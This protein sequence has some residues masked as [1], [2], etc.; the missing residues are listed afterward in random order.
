MI[1]PTTSKLLTTWTNPET[2]LDIYLL[3]EKVAP[4]QQS[5]YFVNDGM[6]A[7]GR[8]LWFYCSYPP[9]GSGSY[10]RTLGLVDFEQ[11]LV[12]HFPDTQFQH[13]SPYVDPANGDVYWT[14]GASIWRRS[15]DPST[16]AECV[17]SLP[18]EIVG[19][20]TV[21]RLATHLSKSVDGTEFFADVA[22]GTQYVFGTL[23]LDGS[24]FRF[25]H[26]F[27][28]NHNHAQFSPIDPDLVLFAEEFHIDPITGLRIPITNRMWSIRR[29][30]APR[31]LLPTPT[32]LSHEWWDEDGTHAWA[33][34]GKQTWRINVETAEVEV[35]EWP[36]NCWH[37]HGTRNG[38]GLICD[39]TQ[40]FYRGCP[41]SVHFLNRRSNT[42]L[43]VIDNPGIDGIAGSNYHIDPHPRFCG[44]DQFVI[45]TATVRGQMDLAIVKTADL[46]DRTA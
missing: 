23:P 12:R 14:T 20:R 5:F 19:H 37:A 46:I 45:F 27:D 6:T 34:R 11:Q 4:S 25:W 42:F 35:V 28:R 2:G 36:V 38:D 17:N 39:S 33:V 30:A 40:K 9:S 3:T 31:P 24:D 10:G 32:V 18:E 13:A 43:K 41:S 22:L 15:P 1:D 29:G 21:T 8:Y 16:A 44:S 7:N 26:R